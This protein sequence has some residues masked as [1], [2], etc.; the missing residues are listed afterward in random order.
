MAGEN[1][2]QFQAGTVILNQGITEERARMVFSEMVP[3]AISAYNKEAYATANCRIERLEQTIMPRLVQL[4][5][6]LS[7]FAEPE[8]QFV[9][10]KAQQS[11]AMTESENDYALLS[12]LLACHIQNKNNRKTKTGV[13]K[14]TEIVSE[15][16]GEA[17]CA[18]TI[19]HAV[20]RL[21]PRADN[22]K[23][24]L[25]IMNEIYGKLLYLELPSGD[26]WIDN[27]EILNAI[28]VLQVSQFKK[29]E[30][31]VPKSWNGIVCAGIMLGSDEYKKAL[32]I[33]SAKGLPSDILRKNELL[34]GYVRI[35]IFNSEA[36]DNLSIVYRES[37]NSIP[38]S[39]VQKQAV[40]SIW[41]LY[42]KDEQRIEEVQKA[43][44]DAWDS[45]SSL[46]K[47]KKW[48][49]SIPQSFELTS[50]GTALAH[51]NA[52]RCDSDIPNLL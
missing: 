48:W 10:C 30:E 34:E 24:A 1:A 41:E 45:Y 17:L 38:F 9:L 6:S 23:E 20:Q 37:G 44:I 5:D 40:H 16:D 15:I 46:E 47:V 22:C 50:I 4:E 21:I 11:A 14:A 29:I 18:M 12:E 19:A 42:S 2:N 36:I 33:I 35:P 28:R 52:Q 26:E 25:D 43:F 39:D 32:E 31:F 7:A 13:L 3:Q 8:F 27:L 51:A 49:N